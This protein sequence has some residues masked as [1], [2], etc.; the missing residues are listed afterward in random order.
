MPIKKQN[1]EGRDSSL[2]SSTWSAAEIQ[3]AGL[4]AC[5]VTFP[6][7]WPVQHCLATANFWR[8]TTKCNDSRS[9]HRFS[10]QIISGLHPLAPTLC[11]SRSFWPIITCHSFDLFISSSFGRVEAKRNPLISGSWLGSLHGDLWGSGGKQ[12][13]SV[14]RGETSGKGLF[15]WGETAK[16]ACCHHELRAV[17]LVHKSTTVVFK[18]STKPLSWDKQWRKE[19]SFL[20]Q[21]NFSVQIVATF[22]PSYVL[23]CFWDKFIKWHLNK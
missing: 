16:K 14:R 6:P 5:V 19:Q 20:E 15:Q 17:K 12:Q 10:R 9:F 8:K 22:C 11:P 1:F 3:T 18:R 13:R 7:P 23:H 2:V 21:K 4:C